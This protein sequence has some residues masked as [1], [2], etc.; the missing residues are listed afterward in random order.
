MVT[1]K[2]GLTYQVIPDIKFRGTIS[3]DIR[4]PNLQELFA[5]GTGRTNTVTV[6]APGTAPVTYQFNEST[7]GN[8]G[9]SPEVAKTYG[10][11]VVITP[12]FLPGLAM[13]A[14]YYN[15]NLSG[16]ISSLTA[17]T[18]VDQCYTAG[19]KDACSFISTSGGRGVV[20]PGL[21]INS[22][23]IKPTNFVSVKTQGIDFEASYRRR[24]GPGDLTLR[25]LAS[26]AIDL[27]TNNGVIAVTDDAGQN[28]GGL[29]NW[30]YRFSAGYDF[31]SGF[32]AQFIARGVSPGNYNNNYIV[33]STNCPA[34]TSDFHTI[35]SNYIPGAFYYDM[36]ANYTIKSGKR[37]FEVFMSVKNI[38]NSDPVLVANGP[39]GNNTPA[40]PQTNRLLYDVLGRVF[41]VGARIKL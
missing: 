12:Q 17:Q 26:Y 30:T 39:N 37:Q 19:I 33:C 36:N 15:I 21:A 28:S 29:P 2:A 1:W 11:G 34:A 23:E 40:Y 35:N 6:S 22:I 7:I 10:A 8:N 25:S 9:L 4:A 38:L 3:R 20:T 31:F 13:S 27:K 5:A 18:L 16:A 14:D 32:G 41:R 24:I